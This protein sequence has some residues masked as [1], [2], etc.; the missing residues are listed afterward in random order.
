[1]IY[2]ECLCP[3]EVEFRR[4]DNYKA[5]GA[6]WTTIKLPG[7]PALPGFFVSKE[8][9]KLAKTPSVGGGVIALPLA[10]PSSTLFCGAGEPVLCFSARTACI[11]VRK[12]WSSSP[13]IARF[14][15]TSGRAAICSANVA[16]VLN[17][18]KPGNT[19]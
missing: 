17:C 5:T 19:G 16:S 18:T 12:S 7:L 4:D 11:L 14:C 15:R 1:M 8:L 6:T 13:F 10:S 9:K 2:Q 3:F